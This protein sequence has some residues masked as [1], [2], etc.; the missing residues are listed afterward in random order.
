MIQADQ[1]DIK[2]GKPIQV[3]IEGQWQLA[4]KQ[5]EHSYIEHWCKTNE[6]EGRFSVARFYEG[7][8]NSDRLQLESEGKYLVFSSGSE[9][10]FTDYETAQL[11]TLGSETVEPIYAGDRNAAHNSVAYEGLIASDG[12]ASTSLSSARILV[13]DTEAAEPYGSDPL[14]GWNGQVISKEDLSSLSDKMGDGT[15]LVR[16]STMDALTTSEE[17]ERVTVKAYEK[18][19]VSADITSLSAD[20]EQVDRVADETT[21]AV[22]RQLRYQAETGVYQFRAASPELPGIAKGTVAYSSWPERLG[23]DAIVSA[24]DIKGDDGRFSEPGVKEA[25]DFWINRK[26]TAEYGQQTVGPQ[27]KYTIPEAT[28]LEI[29][30]R[31]QKKAAQL[32][33]VVGDY[34]A[35][36]QRYLK[37][38]EHE[39][40]RPYQEAENEAVSSRPDWLYSAL[41]SDKYGQLTNEAHIVRGLEH[42]IKGEWQRLSANG[43]S[44]P[45]AMAQHHSQLKP[46]EVCNKDLP[47][48]GNCCLLPFSLSRMSGAAAIAINNIK[49]IE[50]QDA[51][52]FSK[53]GVAYLPP[54]T[55]KNVAITDFDGDINGFFVGYEAATDDL[56]EQLREALETASNLSPDQQYEAGRSALEGLIYQSEQDSDSS[57]EP[58]TYPVA[59]KEF[60]QQTAPEVKPPQIIK[61]QK[62]KHSWLESESHSEATWRAWGITADNPTGKVANAGMSL[63]SLA[64]ELE[65]APD[66]DKGI[67]FNQVSS[68]CSNLLA[69]ADAGEVVIPDDDWLAEQGFSPYYREKLEDLSG[70]SSEVSTYEDVQRHAATEMY[71]QDASRFFLDVANGPNAVNLQTAVDTA[72]SARGIDTNIHKFVEALQYKPDSFRR[73]RNNPLMYVDGKEMPTSIDEPVSWGVQQVNE[74]LQQRSDT[75]EKTCEF[76]GSFS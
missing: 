41:S 67:L 3:A 45:S 76:P 54:D 68:H 53:R 24:D 14:T 22:E 63:Q 7:V 6:I 29:N 18:A 1:F 11:M 28:R 75:G 2:T 59:V 49:I 17:R 58:S 23:V 73:N 70:A 36:S 8:H 13:V 52:A 21:A 42:Y 66:E 74:H 48:R 27:V 61:Q 38:K 19:G 31:V 12:V 34:D 32:A 37:H 39:R 46:W 40:S 50:R 60:I 57:I 5:I 62:E 43:T 26:A 64:L 16:A 51:E 9:G 44:V 25:S 56:P 71:L 47:A 72:K 35:L 55:A 33:Q 4:V 65:Y 20:F 15:M 10:Y 69:K 30:P